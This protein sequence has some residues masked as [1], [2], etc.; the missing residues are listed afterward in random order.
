[1]NRLRVSEGELR[2]L[3]VERLEIID[4]AEF[5][6]ARA[7]AARLRLPLERALVERGRVPYAFLLRQLADAWG[8]AFLDVKAGDVDVEALR[9]VSEEYAR[10]H[11]LV[12]VRL[13]GNVLRVA[14][15][16]PRERRV[17]DE[18]ERMTKL[19]VVPVLAPEIAIARAQLL[20]RGDLRE[21]LERTAAEAG[22]IVTAPGG[23]GDDASATRLLDRI[24]Q[25]AALASASDIHVEPYDL[26]GLVRCRVDGALIEILSLPVSALAP[27]VARVKVLARLRIDE[28][29]VPQD[30][31]FE[32][33]LTGL[34]LDLRV[35]TLPTQWGEKL[36][37]RV[38][39][40]EQMFLDL[41]DLG[42]SER[43]Y[44]VVRERVLAPFGMVLVT[45][46]TGS[47][48]STSLYAILV[49]IAAERQNQ[50][51]IST[52]EDPVEYTLPRVTQTAVHVAGGL[53]FAGGLRALLRQDPD[54]IMVG[55]IRDR[56]TA[57][58]AVRAALVGRL[59]LS[60]L[61]TNDATSAVA[62]LLDMDVEPYLV[63]ST[64]SLVVAQRLVRRICATCRESAPAEEAALAALR[65]RP[66]F[67]ETID[68]L[69]HDGVL[70]TG[71]DPLAAVR[72]FRG[73]GCV[74]C[75]G[76][77][78]RS[79]TGVFE[80][81]AVDD[82]VRRMI[83]DRADGTAIRAAAVQAGMR[84]MFQDG[85]AKAI[86]GETTLDEVI[87]ARFDA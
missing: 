67:A 53:D 78:F 74:Q 3:L 65:A 9:A 73:R 44:V 31:R 24:L 16:D 8:V 13:D 58:I 36:V 84:T 64:L 10:R 41:E 25:Y 35:S 15:C 2:R 11:G 81:F 69:Q 59:L 72:F 45:G 27:L 37:L 34:R 54:V 1:M 30:G 32:V 4:A 52:I 40:K 77:G 43:H 48:K 49:R 6:R 19:T 76:T 51:N 82:R 23:P 75:G 61:H 50:V 83:M 62:R 42:L 63:A 20:Y 26:E 56:E 14:M 17:I 46:P 21:L 47:G 87:R 38:L 79:R 28:R 22:A 55:E 85:L 86:L 66:D 33:D 39:P 60:T 29:R 7:M 71:T 18:I 57:T 68:V 5:D 70:A 80:I 12:P